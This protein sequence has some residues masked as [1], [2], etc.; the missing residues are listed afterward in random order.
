MAA[1]RLASPA[2]IR[3]GARAI[4]PTRARARVSPARAVSRRGFTVRAGSTD[5]DSVE[6]AL[7][8]EGMMCDGCASSVTEALTGASPDVSSVDVN[9]ETKMVTVA[10]KAESAVAGL[11]LMPALVDA[12]KGAGFDAEPEF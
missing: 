4:K 9:L 2:M 1:C 10:V 7:K 3:V 6:I 12:V 11:T 5:D 8:V